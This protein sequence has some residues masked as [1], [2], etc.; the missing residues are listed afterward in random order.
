MKPLLCACVFCCCTTVFSSASEIED[1]V[2]RFDALIAIGTPSN[3]ISA[4]DCGLVNG[5]VT[6][7]GWIEDVAELRGFF[8]P[9]YYSARFNM[10]VRFNGEKVKASSH[11]WRPEVLTRTGAAGAW[12]IE[13]RL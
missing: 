12:K 4:A 11:L 6:F 5:Y 9:P 8:S 1:F 7:N 2:E 3:R 13:S 10:S